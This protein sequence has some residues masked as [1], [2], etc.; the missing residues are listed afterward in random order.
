[1]S[2]RPKPEIENL[3]VCPHGGPDYAELRA[4][5]LTPDEVIDFSV[6]SNPFMPP[7]GIKKILNTVAINRY[8]DSEATELRQ[9]LSEKLGVAPDNIL[10]GNG[11]VELIHLIALTYFGHGDSVLILEPTFGECEVACQINGAVVFKQWARAE[12]NFTPRI[13]ETISLIR[14]RHP[15]G[16]FICNPNNPTGKYLSRQEVEAVLN[17]CADSLLILDEVY[18][19]F[20]DQSWS[21]IDLI[22]QGNVI[23]VRSMTKDYAL[24][25]L[26]LGY[27]IAN[28][29]II[30]SLRRGRLP[31]NVNVV[32]Q[33]AGVIALENGDYL[34]QCQQKIRQA[35]QFLTTE[36]HRIGFLPLPSK[37]NFFLVRVGDGKAFRAALLKHGILVRDCT[38]FDLPEYVRIAPRTMPEC[39]KLITTIEA[40]KSKGELDASI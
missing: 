5:N 34:E 15:R 22:S 4:M 27:T 25:G 23:I 26:R 18:I 16:V 24:A 39:Q 30:D 8:P 3:K 14:Q 35:K 7:P 28:K 40:L 17:A 20:V 29:E 37:A 11:A 33:K 36:L 32:A 21:S 13:E 10:A 9:R 31:W 19:A 12:E 6:S 2:L 1:M 38:S